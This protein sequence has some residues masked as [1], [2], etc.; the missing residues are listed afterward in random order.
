LTLK[1]LERRTSVL[2]LKYHFH[3]LKALILRK[4]E[5]FRSDL[6]LNFF[7]SCSDPV[8]D[9]DPNEHEN[10]DP[11]PN[12]VGSDPQQCCRPIVLN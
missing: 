5:N 7:G 1:L 6:D 8:P 10:K 3:K 11:G 9:P 12:K 4:L 2:V